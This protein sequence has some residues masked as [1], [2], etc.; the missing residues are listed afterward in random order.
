MRALLLTILLIVSLPLLS[1]E[2]G[3]IVLNP[4]TGDLE[5]VTNPYAIG[6]SLVN[7][8]YNNNVAR[9]TLSTM[10][11]FGNYLGSPDCIT[12]GWDNKAGCAQNFSMGKNI[13]CNADKV[14]MIGM[15]TVNA[16]AYM[17]GSV[18]LCPTSEMA[19]LHIHS[20]YNMPN[21]GFVGNMGGVRIG[22]GSL[23]NKDS[24]A[25]EI[26]AHQDPSN[27]RAAS[28]EGAK[29]ITTEDDEWVI[30][31]DAMT[32][33]GSIEAGYVECDYVPTVHSAASDTSLLPTPLKIGDY[34]IDTDARDVYISTGT[35]RGSW[36]KVN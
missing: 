18:A 23:Y 4:L 16:E 28:P 3:H 6:D 24:T 33:A 12:I 7:L 9:Q 27:L 8:G 17:A 25:L 14:I 32:L 11:G 30:G 34:Y 36:K 19:V 10:I 5:Y 35:A 31:T 22:E 21:N 1:Q 26:I 15:S 13:V 20:G 2:S 29:L